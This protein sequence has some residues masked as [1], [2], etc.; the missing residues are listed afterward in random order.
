MRTT[1]GWV[2]VICLSLALLSGCSRE[3]SEPS[4]PFGRSA[5]SAAGLPAATSLKSLEVSARFPG[6]APWTVRLERVGDA[7]VILSRSDRGDGRELADAKLVAHLLSVLDTFATEGEAGKAPAGDLG[8]NPYRVEFRAPGAPEP[9]LQ[10]GE[11]SGANGV[12]FRVAGGKKVWIGRGALFAFLPAIET[13]DAFAHKLP[14]ALDFESIDSVRLEKTS[15]K[16]RGAWE[17]LRGGEAW[18]ARDAK[19]VAKRP[20]TG[21]KA[22]ILER[23]FHQRLLAVLP[24]ARLPDLAH[25][26][27]KITV[28]SQ[29]GREET[30]DLLFAQNN[31]F[32]FNSVRSE[33]SLQ[34]YPEFAGTLRA[35]TQARFT[36]LKS[37]TKK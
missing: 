34:L 2:S 18:F 9:L 23:I 21:E 11:A 19:G 3:P 24:I 10:L 1:P 4:L 27:W 17:F 37:G 20:L 32:G 31:V 30:L 33:R 36:P 29:S 28:R 7:W 16:G 6:I 12:A 14:Y 22:A 8:F 35:F 5:L 25:P 15:G 13:P 26:D